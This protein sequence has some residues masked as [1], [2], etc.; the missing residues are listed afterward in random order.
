MKD[1]SVTVRDSFLFMHMQL[2]RYA[3]TY[4]VNICVYTYIHIYVYKHE[5]I[6]EGNADSPILKFPF[7]P[8]VMLVSTGPSPVESRAMYFYF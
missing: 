4:L 7:V 6:W 2:L 8:V 1:L 3:S 5:C